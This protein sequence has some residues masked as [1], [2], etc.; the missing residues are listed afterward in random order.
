MPAAKPVRA[1]STPFLDDATRVIPY[2]AF[3]LHENVAALL[4][5]F[6]QA[7]LRRGIPQRLYVDNGSAFRSQRLALVCAKVGVALIHG[8]PYQPQ[9]KGKI[10]RWF[11]TTRMQLMRRLS[12]EDT[13]SLDA[14]N[15]RLW[16]WLEGEYHHAPHRGL[17]A[18]TP[19][20]RWAQSAGSVRTAA[21][22]DLDDLFLDEAKRK[23][24]ADR[25]VNLRGRAYEVDAVLVR[26]TV[27]LRFEPDKPN[28]PLEVYNDGHRYADAP[29]VDA[30]ANCFVK[31]NESHRR[32]LDAS[33]PHR[34]EP[35]PMKL[36]NLVDDDDNNND[37]GGR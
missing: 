27:L 19:L 33:E 18:E 29:L 20:D 5:V 15:R 37:E 34:V 17:G 7:L 4:C 24:H 31:R 13:A 21:H 6:K 3:A 9:G 22:L 36:S 8:R 32:T 14:L 35:P 10:E 1:R 16:G 25:T 28:A 11:R 30:Y 26:K 2:A 23:V 12:V